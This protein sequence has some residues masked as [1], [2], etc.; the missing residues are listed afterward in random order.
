MVNLSDVEIPVLLNVEGAD[1]TSGTA[2]LLTA[3]SGKAENTFDAPEYVVP[4]TVAP[5]IVEDCYVAPANSL[6]V[7]RMK[8]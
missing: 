1:I 2:T 8:N 5:L 6:T 3:D 4:K 7:F